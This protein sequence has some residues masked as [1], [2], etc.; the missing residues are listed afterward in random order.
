MPT[1]PS[2]AECSRLPVRVSSMRQS[3]SLL[4]HRRLSKRLVPRH[5]SR[6][7]PQFR[8]VQRIKQSTSQYEA[9]NFRTHKINPET[10]LNHGWRQ[11]P[12]NQSVVSTTPTSLR[13]R[14]RGSSPNPTPLFCFVSFRFD[15]RSPS[16]V[17]SRRTN[18]AC[19][20]HIGRY[21]SCNYTAIH[22]AVC[23]FHCNFSLH[24]SCLRR[25]LTTP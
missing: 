5:L 17:A 1:I 10:A 8:H 4:R 19:D 18:Q 14:S 24:A 22:Y 15:H 21:M 3:V 6:V 9:P 25:R 2:S 23:A 11:P 7:K 12:F 20:R 13:G 16:D